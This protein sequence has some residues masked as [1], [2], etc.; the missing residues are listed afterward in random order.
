MGSC[1]FGSQV[2]T[3]MGEGWGGYVLCLLCGQC[4]HGVI[5]TAAVS[6]CRAQ[7]LEGKYACVKMIHTINSGR[8]SLSCFGELFF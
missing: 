1:Y 2:V 4:Q 3:D 7:M 5:N 6:V 8:G